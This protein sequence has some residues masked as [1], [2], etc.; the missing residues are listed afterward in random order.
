MSGTAPI[1]LAVWRDRDLAAG[2]KLVAARVEVHARGPLGWCT[3]SVSTLA[4]ECGLNAQTV[5]L[6][7]ASLRSRGLLE[8]DARP[9]RTTRLRLRVPD[10]FAPTGPGR[11]THPRRVES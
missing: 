8:I 9:G 11:K 6:G 5:K 4:S 7:L 1:H 3:A 2:A 10:G